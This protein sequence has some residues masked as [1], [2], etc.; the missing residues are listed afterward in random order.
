MFFSIYNTLSKN[1]KT[2]KF[3]IN[4]F[5]TSEREKVQKEGESQQNSSLYSGSNE[6]LSKTA[7]S[8]KNNIYQTTKKAPMEANIEQKATIDERK[9]NAMSIYIYTNLLIIFFIS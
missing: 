9:T 6:N 2:E 5:S 7:N 3:K 4:Y 1:S 8:F